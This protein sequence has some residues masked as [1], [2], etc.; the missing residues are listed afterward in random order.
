MSKKTQK[1]KNSTNTL[2]DVTLVTN[3]VGTIVTPVPVDTNAPRK[4]I[5]PV[6]GVKQTRVNKIMGALNHKD[7][8]SRRNFMR[9]MLTAYTDNELNKRSRK[10]QQEQET[11]NN[12]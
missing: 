11:T 2:V 1:T 5:K 10:K 6:I 4:K 12:D 3:N 9:A 8:F 7:T